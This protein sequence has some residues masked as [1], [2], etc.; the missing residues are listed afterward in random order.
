VR[1]C[2]EL[3]QQIAGTRIQ[4]NRAGERISLAQRL[5]EQEKNRWPERLAA[6]KTRKTEGS[7]HGRK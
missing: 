6:G 4:I 7:K 2:R 1:P 5:R 3:D